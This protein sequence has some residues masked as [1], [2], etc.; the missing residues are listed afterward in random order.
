[1]VAKR[2]SD[3]RDP[4]IIEELRKTNQRPT[5]PEEGMALASKIGAEHYLECSARTKEGVPEVF[6]H[7]TRAALG[8]PS[9]QQCGCVVL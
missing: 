7:A 3:E 8:R 9:G 1:L 4:K 6:Q 2:I 5:T